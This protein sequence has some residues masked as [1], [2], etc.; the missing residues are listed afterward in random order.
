M[1]RGFLSIMVVSLTGLFLACQALAGPTVK[2]G[3]QLPLTGNLAHVGQTAKKVMSFAVEE[4]NA[5]GGINSLSILWVA[6]RLNWSL[7]TIKAGPM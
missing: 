7:A 1:N 3:P 4:V 6:Q 5:Q 2:I